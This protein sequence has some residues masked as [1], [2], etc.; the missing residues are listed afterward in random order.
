MVY[1][2]LPWSDSLQVASA[3]SCIDNRPPKAYPHMYQRLKKYAMEE[4]RM[5]TIQ[6]DNYLLLMRMADIMQK[7]STLDNYNDYE[8]RRLGWLAIQASTQL[9]LE[10][11]VYNRQG[12]I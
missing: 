6:K 11:G 9:A 12:F 1:S 3:K 5:A 8:P 7:K 4:Q 2:I 10:K